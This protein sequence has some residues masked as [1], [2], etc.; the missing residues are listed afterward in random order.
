MSLRPHFFT[1]LKKLSRNELL[2]SEGYFFFR[3][4][5]CSVIIT[6]NNNNHVMNL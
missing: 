5:V 1:K 2:E 4:T 3:G 6:S